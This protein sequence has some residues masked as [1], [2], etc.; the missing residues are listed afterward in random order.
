MARPEASKIAN[1]LLAVGRRGSLAHWHRPKAP[2]GPFLLLFG[3]LYA[4]FGAAS[5]FLPALMEARG[6]P[7]EQIGILFGAATAIRLISAPLAARIADRTQ[8]LRATL[9]VCALATALTA[10]GYVSAWGFW[11]LFVVGLLHAVALAPTT[12][13]ADALALVASKKQGFEYGWA[14][15]AGSAAFIVASLTAGV[16][17]SAFGLGV[18]VALQ[19]TLM[20]AVPFAIAMVPPI[21]T[22]GRTSEQVSRDGILALARL[23]AFRRVVLVAAMI[24]GSHALHDTFSVIRWTNA[25]IS[26]Q[27]A[28]L[29]WSLAVAAEVVVFFVVGPRIVERLG[30]ALT[31][32]IAAIAGAARWSISALTLDLAAIMLIQPL[33]GV[34]FGLLHLACMR[35]LANSVPAELAA[36]G[37]AIYGTVGVGGASALLTIA[38]GWLYAGLGA[39]AFLVMSGLCIAALPVALALRHTNR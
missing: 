18:V 6:L 2:V 15:G 4:A 24:L 8:A 31:I 13:L 27:A 28:S 12:N 38:S 30:P 11:G 39:Q 32:A 33:H 29:L 21:D 26:P 17:V 19:A 20:L 3:L 5:P 34:T 16:A 14:R 7:V 35:L 9:A 10:M 1:W 22:S 23:P 37:Q 36:T 25:G